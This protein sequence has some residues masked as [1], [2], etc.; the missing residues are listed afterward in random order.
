MVLKREAKSTLVGKVRS[1]G[2]QI[3]QGETIYILA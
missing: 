1:S 3:Y 2:C